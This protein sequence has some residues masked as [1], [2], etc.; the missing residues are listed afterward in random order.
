[1]LPK[2]LPEDTNGKGVIGLPDVPGLTTQEMQERFDQLALE[3]IVPK[4]NELADALNGSGGAGSIGTSSGRTI[5]EEFEELDEKKA[6]VSNVLTKDQ[7]EEYTPTGEYNPATKKYVDDKVFETGAADMQKSVYDPQSAGIDITLQTYTCTTSGT[8]HA[9]TG[10]GNNIKFVADA[11]F[12]E[13]DT[14][15]VN[16]TP[17]TAQT[18]GGEAL[19]EGCFV[20]GAVVSCFQNEYTL[21][22]GSGGARIGA[23]AHNA[24]YRGKFLGNAV[25]SEQYAAISAGTFDDLYIGD[26]WTIGDVNYRVAAFDYY[27]H[28]GDTET[29]VHHIVL[30]PDTSLY[31]HV[32]NDT[33]ITTGAYVGSKMYTE[34]L[35]Q[36]KT[37][38]KAAFSGHVLKHRI[39]LANAAAN[40]RV[41]AFVWCDS[42]ADLMCEHMVYGNGIFSPVSDGTNVPFNH[43]VEKGQLP[44]FQHDPSCISN[45]TNWCLR[46]V[47]TVSHFASV[48]NV[49][50]ASYDLA[51]T[52]FSVRPFFCIYGGED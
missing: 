14:F 50:A 42:V 5:E 23:G 29:T 16:G 3:V 22:F 40:G 31:N 24:I 27:L 44:L 15:T 7:T 25:T 10:T 36:A 43:R 8:V 35:E 1:M 2:I 9:L 33:N 6:D 46:D 26:Y 28:C 49:G 48:S 12:A 39:L 32:M 20:A 47:I 17:C 11:A 30:V 45:R 38:I 18:Q 4:F 51:S 41:S 21:T 37:T 13:G 34:G 52:Y 19:S